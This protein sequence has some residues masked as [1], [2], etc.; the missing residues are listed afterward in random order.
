MPVDPI[1]GSYG[2]TGR[3][4][5]VLSIE[6]SLDPERARHYADILVHADRSAVSKLHAFSARGYGY[7]TDNDRILVHDNWL[8]IQGDGTRVDSAF[9]VEPAYVGLEPFGGDADVKWYQWDGAGWEQTGSGTVTSVGTTPGSCYLEMSGGI[10]SGTYYPCK[11]T[12]VVPAAFT[13]QNAEWVF[14]LYS[15]I[16]DEDGVVDGV[17]LASIWEDVA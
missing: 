17:N 4:G 5:V 13:V 9:F 6:E 14:E 7:D 16:G 2:I 8:A 12:I 1:D 15:G 10:A 3:R 11:D